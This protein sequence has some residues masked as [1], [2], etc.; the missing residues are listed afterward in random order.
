MTICRWNEPTKAN[1][2]WLDHNLLSFR[3]WTWDSLLFRRLLLSVFVVSI[4]TTWLKQ[5]KKNIVIGMSK[6]KMHCTFVFCKWKWSPSPSLSLEFFFWTFHFYF[7][8]KKSFQSFVKKIF[9]FVPKNVREI[10]VLVHKNV[11]IDNDMTII[12]M[13]FHFHCN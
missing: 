8:K 1:R 2:D 10:W 4:S 12:G 11:I 5:L 13:T 9:S 3:C 7:V 6:F